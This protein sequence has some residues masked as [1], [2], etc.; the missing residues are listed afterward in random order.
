[1]RE[2][3]GKERRLRVKRME[4]HF[5]Y[6]YEVSTVKP[7]KLCLIKREKGKGKYNGG[8]ELVQHTLH[9]YGINTVNPLQYECML[10]QKSNVKRMHEHKHILHIYKIK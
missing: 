8:G 1:M 2:R 3:K 9:M 10:I 5:I 7:S 6:A 4:V